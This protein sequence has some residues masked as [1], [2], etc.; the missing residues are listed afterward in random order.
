MISFNISYKFA[1]DLDY[2]TF[3]NLYIVR[4]KKI[5]TGEHLY[6]TNEHIWWKM[7]FTVRDT[8]STLEGVQYCGGVPSVL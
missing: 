8:I 6:S 2:F 4:S 1:F 5:E 3:M 7:L